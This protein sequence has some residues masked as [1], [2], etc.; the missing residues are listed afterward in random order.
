MGKELDTCKS[1][2]GDHSGAVVQ[3]TEVKVCIH[4][5]SGQ[6]RAVKIYKRDKL[7]LQMRSRIQAEI[8]ML[9]SLDHPNLVR[10]FQVFRDVNHI[11]LVQE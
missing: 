8:E 9:Q 11:Y 6:E 3:R 5:Q 10:P 4:K 2:L 7:N 1:T